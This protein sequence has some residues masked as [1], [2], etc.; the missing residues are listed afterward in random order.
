MVW[1]FWCESGRDP[2]I[3]KKGF[4]HIHQ[5]C[6]DEI[7]DFKTEAK[8]LLVLL[9]DKSNQNS[10]PLNKYLQEREEFMKRWEIFDKRF[11]ELKQLLT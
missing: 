7:L 4:C 6:L 11:D 3:S 2:K 5:K 1:C 8:E 9:K 10:E